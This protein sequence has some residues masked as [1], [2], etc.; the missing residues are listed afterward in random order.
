MR[1]GQGYNVNSGRQK[2][3]IPPHRAGEWP[4]PDDVGQTKS[5]K[6]PGEIMGSSGFRY[7]P[8]VSTGVPIFAF[9]LWRHPRPHLQLTPL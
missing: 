3:P 8:H 5:N 9:G 4:Q 7:K 6:G 1:A 2:H